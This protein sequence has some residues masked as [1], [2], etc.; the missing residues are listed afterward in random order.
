M[1]CYFHRIELVFS[2][3]KGIFADSIFILFVFVVVILV[4]S[5]GSLYD[6]IRLHSLA[7]QQT[8]MLQKPILQSRVYKRFR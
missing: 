4:M 7:G 6:N 5:D 8:Q 2:C 3:M 1:R